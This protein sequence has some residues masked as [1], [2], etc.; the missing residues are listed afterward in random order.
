MTQPMST[1]AVVD[2]LWSLRRIATADRAKIVELRCYLD[3][4]DGR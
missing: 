2:A 4:Y 1:S 3:P